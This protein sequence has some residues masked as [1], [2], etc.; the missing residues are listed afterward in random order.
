MLELYK[1]DKF[2]YKSCIRLSFLTLFIYIGNIVKIELFNQELT[3]NFCIF[4]FIFHN[5]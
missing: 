4:L 2:F 1:T 5:S 3:Y